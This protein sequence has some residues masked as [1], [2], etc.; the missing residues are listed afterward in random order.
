MITR[1]LQRIVLL[2]GAILAAANLQV[3][4]ELHYVGV[5]DGRFL[6]ATLNVKTGDTVVWIN[7]DDSAS[8]TTTSDV[9]FPDP[10]AWHALLFAQG[11]VF[12]KVFNNPGNFTYK[13]KADL[14]TGTVIVTAVRAP[15]IALES[16]R[17]S[18]GQFLFEATGLTVGKASVLEFSTNLIHWTA[19][20]TNLAN[21]IS[22]T[23]TNGVNPGA[24]FFRVYQLP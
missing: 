21:N 15:S 6:P 24:R 5:D 14:G 9:Q 20:S 2:G 4:G 19:V 23:F 3:R 7:L 22:M 10:N 1:I 18:G 13:D 12:S 17:M 11:D 8:H 16:P